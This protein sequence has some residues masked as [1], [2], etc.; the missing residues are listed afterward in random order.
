MLYSAVQCAVQA[1]E[2]SYVKRVV[3]S[4]TLTVAQLTFI[5]TLLLHLLLLL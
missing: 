1:V 2:H 3:L 4:L 5:S